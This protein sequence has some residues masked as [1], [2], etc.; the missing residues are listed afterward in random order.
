MKAAVFNTQGPAEVLTY[1]EVEKP[2]AKY[3]E[4]L[5]KVH[6]TSINPLDWKIR[7]GGFKIITFG[8]TP[9]ILGADLSGTVEAVGK[10][11]TRFKPGDEVF[12]LVNVYSGKGGYAQY[13]TT[14]ADSLSLKPASVSFVEAAALPVVALTALQ[15]FRDKADLQPGQHVLI[16]GAS[17]GVGTM[18]VQLAKLMGAEVTGVCS[19]KNLD[20]VKSLGADHV[21]DYTKTDFT[22]GNVLYDVVFD[23]VPNSSF[24]E[25]SRIMKSKSTYITTMPR[26]RSLLM[27]ALTSISPGKKVKVSM[28]GP[29]SHQNLDY[30]SQL[31]SQ[32][33]LKVVIDKVYPLSEA[34]QAHT[35]AEKGHVSGK[36]VLQV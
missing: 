30:I 9:F 31:V 11:V 22:K 33:K 10:G 12:G 13:A 17:G 2:E 7:K 3:G 28:L 4:V 14:D 19:T 36:V 18:A 29:N 34:A 27:T 32:G 25:S 6:A 23:V 24:S 20:L 21:I 35:Y 26:P 16:N 15:A 5:V 1:A 8:R